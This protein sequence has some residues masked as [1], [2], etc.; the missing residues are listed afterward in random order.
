MVL[1]YKSAADVPA[2][3]EAMA[4]LGL[5]VSLGRIPAESSTVSAMTAVWRGRGI[6]V[7]RPAAGCP[8]IELDPRWCEPEPPLEPRRRADLDRKST[9]LN[10]SHDQISYAVFCLKKKKKKKKHK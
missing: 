1:I 4:P 2:L 3:A 5:P 9:R 7:R 8:W 10:S 6:V